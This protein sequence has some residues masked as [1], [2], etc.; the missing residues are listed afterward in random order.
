MGVQRVSEAEATMFTLFWRKFRRDKVFTMFRSWRTVLTCRAE[1]AEALRRSPRTGNARYNDD[2]RRSYAHCRNR[3][4]LA[5]VSGSVSAQQRA[6]QAPPGAEAVCTVRGRGRAAAK[7][8][9]ERKEG[10]A[11]LAQP[12]GNCT[13][14]A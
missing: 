7:A 14:E 11:L 5:L 2:Q 1:T 3:L 4:A 10:Q 13:A 9:S 8:K 6:A 12:I